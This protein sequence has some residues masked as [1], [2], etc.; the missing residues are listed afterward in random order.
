MVAF[1]LNHRPHET[2][3]GKLFLNIGK[4]FPKRIDQSVM[5][6]FRPSIWHNYQLS[7]DPLFLV[8]WYNKGKRL[9][10]DILHEDGLLISHRELNSKYN[11][12]SNIFDYQRTKLCTKNFMKNIPEK[13]KILYQRPNIPFHF[14]PLFIL[15]SGSKDV[16]KILTNLET[17][18]PSCK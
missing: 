4:T 18:G 3:F 10:G 1:H 7:K 17:Q 5:K 12:S 6:I 11:L 8:S 2:I 15:K 14:K 16:Y 13:L 9:V